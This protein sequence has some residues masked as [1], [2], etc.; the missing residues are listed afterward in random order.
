[1]VKSSSLGMKTSRGRWSS[2][3]NLHCARASLSSAA[4]RALVGLR[5][6]SQPESEWGHSTGHISRGNGPS[7]GAKVMVWD[8][9]EKHFQIVTYGMFRGGTKGGE[10]EGSGWFWGAIN[11]GK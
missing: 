6:G 8:T 9:R 10:K 3:G 4:P 11:V 7:L 5:C 2:P 1:M